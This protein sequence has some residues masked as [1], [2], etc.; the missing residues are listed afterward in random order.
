MMRSEPT[1][2]VPAC[3]SNRPGGCS[4]CTLAY[5]CASMQDG[6]RIAPWPLAALLVIGLMSLL[7]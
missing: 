1:V 7:I 3:K 4:T 6:G 5:D 2:R